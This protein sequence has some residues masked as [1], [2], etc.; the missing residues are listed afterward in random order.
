MTVFRTAIVAMMLLAVPANAASRAK[1]IVL[2]GGDAPHNPNIH[3]AALGVERLATALSGSPDLKGKVT[4]R[5]FPRGWPADPAALDGA[6]TVV[7]YFDG[8]DRHPLL[9]PARRTAL[10][11]LMNRGVGLVAFHQ[12]ST[13]PPDDKSVPLAGWLGGARYGMVDRTVEEA[14]FTPTRHPIGNGVGGFA[15]RDE[16]YPTLVYRTGVMPILQTQL[17]LEANPAAPPTL[18]TVAWAYTRPAGGRGFGF[19]G[20]HYLDTLDRPELRKLMLNGIVWSAGLA[21][22]AHGVRSNA[23][24]LSPTKKDTS[25]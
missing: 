13:L 24:W 19:T 16:F 2:I 3:D 25:E 10:A 6:A 5:S 12:A 1:V 21:V 22:P 7:L 23:A 17:H 9:D 11:T 8:L 4:V 15:Y 20:F 18:R 14:S